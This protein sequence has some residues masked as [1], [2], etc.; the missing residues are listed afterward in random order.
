VV[1]PLLTTKLHV[2]AGR[3]ST[4]VRPRLL[5]RLVD[6]REARLTLVSAPAGFGKSTLLAQWIN[7]L[8]TPP[9]WVSLDDRDNDSLTFWSYVIAALQ[10]S[11]GA[12]DGGPAVGAAA[13]QTLS[14]QQLA[15]DTALNSLINDLRSADREAV[16]VLD[17]YHVI[18]NSRVHDAMTY[19]LEHLPERVHVVIATR[20]DPPFPLARLRARGELVEVRAAH[21]RFTHDETATY[22]T[23]SMG[24]ALTDQ[25]VGTLTDR[26]EGWASA[27]QLAGISLRDEDDPSAAVARFAGDDRFVVDYL[28]DEVLA[29][30]PEDVREFLLATSILDRMT[31]PLCE[32]VTGQ[33]GGAARLAQL[34][35]ANLFVVS[36]DSGRHWYRYHHLFADVL[37]V[38]LREVYGDR[39]AD[40]HRRAAEWLHVNGD[41]VDAI[42]HALA[43]KDHGRAAEIMETAMPQMRRERREREL[44]RWVDALPDDVVAA[45]PVLA[46]G[47]V[48]ALAQVSSFDS[49]PRRLDDAERLLRPDGGAWPEEPPAGLIVHDHAAYR[50]APA[51]IATYRAAYA[52]AHGDLSG[53]VEWAR[54]A[55]TLVPPD[56]YMVQAAASALGGLAAWADGDL[57]AAHRAYEDT[58]RGLR[59]AG[60]TADVLGVSITLGDIRRTQ[61][62]LTDALATYRAALD[63]SPA[64]GPPSGALRGTADM[65]IGIAG[66]LLERD[67]RD[68]AAAQLEAADRFGELNGLPQNPYRRRVVAA[69]LNDIAGDLDAALRL[70]DEAD[71]FYVGDFAPNVQPVPAVRARLHLRRGDLRAAVAWARDRSLSA[72]DELS[73]LREYEHVTFARIL[74]TRHRVDRDDAALADAIALLGRLEIAAEAGGRHGTVIEIHVLQAVAHFVRGDAAAAVEALRRAV[75]SAECEG[76]VRVFADEG[77]PAVA[78]LKLLSKQDLPNSTKSYVHR[79]ITAATATAHDGVASP[80]TL[81]EPLSDREL[82]VLRLLATDLAGPEIARHLHVSLNTV[83]THT[84]SIFRKLQVGTRRA[85]VREATELGLLGAGRTSP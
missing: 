9:A 11:L 53:T 47:F 67:D 10:R 66:V 6:V 79:L 70:L 71:R 72:D 13:L 33:P 14:G 84:R 42:G 24:L 39:V 20:S 43:A 4:V 69:R 1:A 44:V 83:R 27:L 51:T 25:D 32:A 52:L 36:L 48:G 77:E 55:M 64:D 23:G 16:L 61:G 60:H 37:R 57:A 62:R 82:D 2:P 31:G 22:L 80:A 75:E 81:I 65:H 35:R 74:M 8:A 45:R 19:I 21:L 40:L 50:A 7:D 18:D 17:D 54:E 76:Y 68:G 59:R 38:H 30:Q 78:V 5:E 73:Y 12:E 85:A 28:A 29:R 3:A 63:L 56:E 34:E 26:T 49:L 58:A 41:P 46:V 15:G